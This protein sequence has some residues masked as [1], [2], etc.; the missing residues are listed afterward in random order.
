MTWRRYSV[1]QHNNTAHVVAH[2]S[3]TLF[4]LL[5]GYV[6]SSHTPGL[7]SLTHPATHHSHANPHNLTPPTHPALHPSTSASS[8]LSYMSSTQPSTTT[9]MATHPQLS[10]LRTGLTYFSPGTDRGMGDKICTTY[11]YL[12]ARCVYTCVC[13]CVMWC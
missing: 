3:L 13:V 5:H 7:M 2:N 4:A 8:I 9:N 11:V 6:R 10:A 1:S 12:Y